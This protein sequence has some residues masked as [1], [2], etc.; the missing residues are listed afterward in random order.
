MFDG[1]IALS[2]NICIAR[3]AGYF[4]QEP[5]KE[6]KALEDDIEH[7]DR[8]TLRARRIAGSVLEPIAGRLE[9]YGHAIDGTV[10]SIM[11]A[12]KLTRM[13]IHAIAC[14]CCGKT[15]TGEEVAERLKSTPMIGQLQEQVDL[16]A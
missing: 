13:G 10:G 12:L 2:R 8:E 1:K 5:E 6:F 4:G 9:E 3:L 11:D 16:A 7:L 15:I 14:G